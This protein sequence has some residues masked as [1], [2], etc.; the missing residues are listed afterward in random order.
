MKMRIWQHN[1]RLH[2]LISFSDLV[3]FSFLQPSSPLPPN[4]VDP[5]NMSVDVGF[6]I[7]YYCGN[8]LTMDRASIA[9]F[10]GFEA[11]NIHI[12]RSAPH[13]GFFWSKV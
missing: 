7:P 13:L 2:L 10:A 12:T 6:K 9:V 4:I 3:R 11:L 1:R 5:E 8:I